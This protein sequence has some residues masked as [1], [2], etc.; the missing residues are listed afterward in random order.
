MNYDPEKLTRLVSELNE[1]LKLLRDLAVV[2][3]E[4]FAAD[5]HKVSSAKYNFI[6][7]IEAVIDISNHL[8][9]KNSFRVPEDYADTFRVL[10]DN[11]VL[12]DDF[13]RRLSDMARF[14]NRLVH[15]Y[16]AVDLEQLY[17][18]LSTELDDFS[19]FKHYLTEALR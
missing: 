5:P 17:G 16:W 19:R 4:D 7:A 9:S 13:A 14:R 6:V 10:T 11:S 2:P 18:M 15:L 3:R 1:A 12:P 8:I